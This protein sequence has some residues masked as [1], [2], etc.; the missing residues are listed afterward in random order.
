MYAAMWRACFCLIRIAR[1]YINILTSYSLNASSFT[2]KVG[3]DAVHH[4]DGAVARPSAPPFWAWHLYELS[5]TIQPY[6][7]E[8]L[9]GTNRLTVYKYGPDG[10]PKNGIIFGT[11]RAIQQSGF[12]L[13]IH[14]TCPSDMEP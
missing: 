14:L 8:E 3:V 13:G 2:T 10:L 4:Q 7:V 1:V 5:R 11:S 12:C 6:L 9:G